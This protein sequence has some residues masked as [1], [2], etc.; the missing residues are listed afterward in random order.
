MSQLPLS[1]LLTAALA[2]P[3]LSA[4]DSSVQRA[5]QDWKAARGDGWILRVNPGTGTG[6]LL[7]GGSVEP[8]FR[9]FADSE[10]ETLARIVV[11]EVFPMFGIEDD[12]LRLRYVKRLPLQR[13]GTAPKVAA[14]FDQEVDGVPVVGGSASVLFDLHGRMLSVDTTGLPDLKAVHTVPALSSAVAFSA[15]AEEFERLEGRVANQVEDEGLVIYQHRLGSMLLPRLAWS[16]TVGTVDRASTILLAGRRIY[17]SADQQAPEVLGT[18]QLLHQCQQPGGLDGQVRTHATPGEL[19]DSPTNSEQPFWTE[20]MEVHSR[21]GSSVTDANGNFSIPYGGTSTQ[22]V[23][24]RFSGPFAAVNNDAGAEYLQVG[25]VTPGTVLIYDLNQPPDDLVTA[26]A[27]AFLVINKFHAFIAGIDPNDPTMD[28]KVTANVN[29]VGGTTCPAWYWPG[30]LGIGRSI[31]FCQG[32]PNASYSTVIAHEEG[33]WANDNY[34]SGNGPDGFGEGTAD[35]WAMYLFDTPDL[36][37]DIFGPGSGPLRSG[38]NTRPFC[39]DAN[40][41]CNGEVHDDG[42]VLMGALWKVRNNLN[43]TLGNTL[44]DEEANA[45]YLSWM[46]AYDDSRITTLIRDHWLILDDDNGSLLDGTPYMAEVEAGF[47]AQGFPAFSAC[48]P[49]SGLTERVSVDSNGIQGNSYS[50]YPSISEDGRFVAFQSPASNLVPGDTNGVQD[51]FVHDR[52]TGQTERISVDSSGIQG[53]D[54]SWYPSISGDGRFVAFQSLA[55]NLVTGDTNAVSDVFIHDIWTGQTRRVSEDSNGGEGN[56]WSAFSSIS[57]DGRFVAFLSFASNL[58][59]GDTNST[60]D[61]FVHDCQTG[62]TVRVS[63][64]S[65]GIQGN[66]DSLPSSISGDGRFVAFLSQA[67]NLVPGDTNGVDDVFVHDRHMAHTERVSMDSTGVQGNQYSG[68]SSIS[69][70]GRL[71]AFESLATNLVPGD[72]NGFVDIFVHDRQTGRTVRVSVD[73]AGVQGNRT[74]YEPS[75]S[76]DGR[77][78]AFGSLATNLVSRDTNDFG[79][80]FV[81][82]RPAAQTTRVSVDSSGCQGT[83]DSVSPS[84]SGDGRSVAFHSAASN[85]VPGDTN[86]TV[87]VFVHEREELV[88]QL[89]QGALILGHRVWFIVSGAQPGESVFYFASRAGLGS[90]NCYPQFG[91]LCLDILPPELFLGLAVAAAS[92]EALHEVLI[93]AGLSGMAYTQAVV[94]RGPG[95][96]DSVK[97]N[98]VSAP[99]LP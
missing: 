33:H 5:F 91:G 47:M 43:S 25:L 55:N 19:P 50:W 94:L 84:M 95:G 46:Q 72:S 62:Q 16:I 93:P 79:D 73:S 34:R 39:G 98:T 10:W 70:D 86:G 89:S 20:G 36:G 8:T 31:N 30:V 58:V 56:S 3:G 42:E 23:V 27:N 83:Y 74:S 6:Q 54:E 96:A 68:D 22:R 97:T 82:D 76:G 81:H 13:A 2:A 41:G 35:T 64:D 65:N 60:S 75:I 99:L 52:Q 80:I 45:L 17:V 90:G 12:T 11:D 4:Q 28:Q 48:P 21:Y 78:V 49:S 71:V 67:T 14:V 61:A 59:P 38:W 18:D 87:D 88:P 51:V 1:F 9:P 69:D 37:L 77:F 66:D 53:N 92:G 85:L 26:Q 57:R 44:G 29:I 40:P 7:F 24:F 63:V 15:A 32:P